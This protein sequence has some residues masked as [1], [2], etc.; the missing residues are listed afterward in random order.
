MKEKT[1]W[2]MLIIVVLISLITIFMNQPVETKKE[3]RHNTTH[4]EED[5][6]KIM[7]EVIESYEETSIK[8]L[9]VYYNDQKSRATEA[10]YMKKDEYQEVIIVFVEFHTGFFHVPT[11]LGE[12]QHYIDFA[13]I[14]GQDL[15][16]QWEWID[17]GYL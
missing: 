15:Q 14:Y 5:I 9:S 12:N 13:H 16:G 17:G 7:D 10:E 4:K 1:K 2:I 8:V 6:D 3:I 11:G